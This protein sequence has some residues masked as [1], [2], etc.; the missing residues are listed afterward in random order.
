MQYLDLANVHKRLQACHVDMDNMAMT[1]SQ[2]SSGRQHSPI[3]AD[4][5]P[6]RWIQEDLSLFFR[7]LPHGTCFD[8][9]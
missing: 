3:A 9:F 8:N 7:G 6:G 4:L 5:A 2:T 1:R